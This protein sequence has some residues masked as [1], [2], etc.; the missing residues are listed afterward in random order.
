M[1]RRRGERRE[2]RRN[3]V[4]LKHILISGESINISYRKGRRVTALGNR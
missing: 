2:E 4:E 3:T 1:G